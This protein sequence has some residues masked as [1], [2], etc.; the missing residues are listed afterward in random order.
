MKL[1]R[2]LAAPVIAGITIGLAVLL[3]H[4]GLPSWQWDKPA[5]SYATAVNRAVPA[6]V[7]IYTTQVVSRSLPTDDPLFDRFLEAPR[8]Q[9]LLSS[10]GSGVI[11]SSSGY[12][13]TSHHVVRD[14]DEIFVS[15]A[16]GREAVARVV[17]EDPETDL[18]VLK[19][20]MDDLPT[21]GLDSDADVHVGDVVL[22]IGNPL[23]VGQTVSMGI[24]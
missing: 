19:I 4:E 2:F 23:G 8:R 5:D 11:V 7:N 16:D 9:R 13:L 20:D 17:G 1:L 15:L 10:L 3:W 12:L 21:L 18:A 14:A 6:V 22:A 24:V